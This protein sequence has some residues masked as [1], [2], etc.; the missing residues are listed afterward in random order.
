LLES[1]QNG[2]ACLNS[3]HKLTANEK[4]DNMIRI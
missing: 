3:L 4:K 1:A 2:E